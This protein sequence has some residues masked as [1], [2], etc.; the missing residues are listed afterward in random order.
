MGIFD[1]YPFIASYVKGEEA[2]L[3]T[4]EHFN[5]LLKVKDVLEA[6]EVIRG[7]DVG[8]YL[9]SF[10]F[11]TFD[12]L[13]ERLWLYFDE[14]L[15]FIKRLKPVPSE[16]QNLINIYMVKY[17][18]LNIKASLRNL[19]TGKKMPFIP[20][21]TLNDLRFLPELVN[22]SSV[23]GVID[24]LDRCGLSDYSALITGYGTA[25]EA[26]IRLLIEAKLD[27]KY[28]SNFLKKARKVSDSAVF[29]RVIGTLMDMININLV[30]RAIAKNVGESVVPYTVG[31]GYLISSKEV[32]GLL[33]AKLKDT[34]AL[35]PY[36]YRGLA[37]EIAEGY[38]KTRSATVIEGAVDRHEFR[39]L[40]EMLSRRLMSPLIITWYLI[41]KE[42]EIKNL[43]LVFK[44][45]FDG[46]L[47]E[48]IKD[49]LVMTS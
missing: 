28:Y 7:T 36:L 11:K 21:G 42:T 17:D 18:V 44:A 23:D 10:P 22:A 43:R 47:P 13:D 46:R 25:A 14:S 30:F 41:L 16:I 12:E 39:L 1:G 31:D 29:I 3:I 49:S 35:V 8:N 34:V 2:H 4:S 32:N 15:K 45:V 33:N 40:T 26:T 37:S 9:G 6:L 19:S 48:E 27:R 20:L 5:R 24:I 38:E